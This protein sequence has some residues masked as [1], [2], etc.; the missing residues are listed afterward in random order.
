MEYDPG[1]D[2]AEW[3]ARFTG[4]EYDPGIDIAED[5][6]VYPPSDDSILLI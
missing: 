6:E 2:I 3:R 4:M 1:I 5:P